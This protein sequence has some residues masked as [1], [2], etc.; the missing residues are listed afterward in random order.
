MPFTDDFGDSGLYTGDVN[1]DCRPNGQ[2][3]M[4]YENGVFFEGKWNDGKRE[5]NMA[6]RERIM[7]GFTSWKGAGK[8]GGGNN[9]VHGMA[10]IDRFGKAGQYTGDVN[11]HSVPHGKGLM[12]YDFGLIAEGEWV[13][14]ILIDGGQQPVGGMGGMAVAGQTVMEGV[15]GGTVFPGMANATM[16]SGMGMG[17]I[18]TMGPTFP[19]TMNMNAAMGNVMYGNQGP[20]G[21]PTFR[22]N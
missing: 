13:N 9:T 22:K 12:K 11:E 10:W 20:Q 7:S 14:G 16:V 21:P 17:G 15:P 5:G 2:G 6:Q 18:S 8:K 4:K 3:R 1:E 19:P